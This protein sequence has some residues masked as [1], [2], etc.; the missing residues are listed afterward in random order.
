MAIKPV[1][2]NVVVEKTQSLRRFETEMIL[3]FDLF[4]RKFGFGF[5]FF[6]WED[7]GACSGEHGSRRII[8]A[9][10]HY[11]L[12]LFGRSFFVELTKEREQK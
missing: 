11:Q 12:K 4:H 1:L 8:V 10:L 3:S 2:A 7:L 6:L 5:T 9:G